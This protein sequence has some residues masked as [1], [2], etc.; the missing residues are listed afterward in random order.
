MEKS[1]TLSNLSLNGVYLG[2][3]KKNIFQTFPFGSVFKNLIIKYISDC[4]SY[5][6]RRHYSSTFGQTKLMN[7]MILC[8]ED[9]LSGFFFFFNTSSY[10]YLEK[11][12]KKP[13]LIWF[14]SL[15]SL[16]KN[17][18]SRQKLYY[19]D[20]SYWFGDEDIWRLTS[21]ECLSR[22]EMHTLVIQ[23]NC[24]PQIPFL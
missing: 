7:R 9:V 8:A 23:L 22:E 18:E 3:I 12:G 11:T 4:K 14:L 10:Q 13:R 20:S 24:L 21:C 19:C 17:W 2:Q 16:C 5:Q 6:S 15:H 1:L